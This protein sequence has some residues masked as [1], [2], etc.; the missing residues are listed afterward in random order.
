MLS[1]R[2]AGALSYAAHL[3]SGQRRKG[4]A[5]PYIARFRPHQLRK[6][7]RNSGGEP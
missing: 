6:R 3:H 5:I 2:F 7:T 1:G 4:I